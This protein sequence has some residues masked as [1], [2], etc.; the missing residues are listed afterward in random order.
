MSDAANMAE[1]HGHMLGELS[2]LVLELARDLQA[3]ALAA[4]TPADAAEL[5]LAF[6]RVARSLRQTLAL[7]AKLERD[8]HRARRE[9]HAEAAREDIARRQRLK[10]QVRLSVERAIWTEAEGDEA[11]R[12]ADDLDDLLDAY[13]LAD[14][15]TVTPVEA[16]IARIRHDLGLAADEAETTESAAATSPVDFDAAPAPAGYAGRRSSA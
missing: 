13:A 10:T 6:H 8:R 3:R 16:H 2:E 14:D 5:S 7:E 11:E 1:R 15:F 4:E 12:L 9:D